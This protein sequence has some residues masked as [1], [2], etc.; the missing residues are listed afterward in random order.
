M[1]EHSIA[2]HGLQADKRPPRVAVSWPWS[3][4]QCGA[5]ASSTLR[6]LYKKSRVAALL[7]IFTT[8]DRGALVLR[9]LQTSR[10]QLTFDT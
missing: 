9:H 8:T 5:L 3:W 2:L 7:D 1:V 4:L 10:S 6:V